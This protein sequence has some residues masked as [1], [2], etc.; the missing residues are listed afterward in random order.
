MAEGFK[1]ET[2]SLEMNAQLFAD[3]FKDEHGLQL[4]FDDS[5]LRRLVERA[6]T[7]RMTM[8]ELCAHLFKDF[9]FGLDLIHKNTGQ[10]QFVLDGTAVDQ[11]DKFLSELVLQSYQSRVSAQAG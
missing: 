6:H 9:R 2:A 11:P 7:E 10:T 3:K 8:S 4:V 1:Q 5:A